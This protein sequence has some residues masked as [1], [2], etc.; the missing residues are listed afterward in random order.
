MD[1]FP[2]FAFK[3]DCFIVNVFFSYATNTQALQQ[4]S[5]NKEN[6]RFVGFTPVL[7]LWLIKLTLQYS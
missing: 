5:E 7:V 3:L 6:Q 2:F 1:I 4:K